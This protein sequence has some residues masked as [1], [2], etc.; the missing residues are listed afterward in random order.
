MEHEAT[1]CERVLKVS[2]MYLFIVEIRSIEDG[3]YSTNVAPRVTKIS[4]DPLP[5]NDG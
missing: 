4:K 1:P 3:G 5:A 2:H